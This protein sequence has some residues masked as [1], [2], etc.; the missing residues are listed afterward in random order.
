MKTKKAHFKKTVLLGCMLFAAM[1]FFV[2]P[3]ILDENT[4]GVYY[5]NHMGTGD[6][7]PLASAFPGETIRSMSSNPLFYIQHG[8]GAAEVL[9]MGI[10]SDPDYHVLPLYRLSPVIAVNRAKTQAKILGWRDLVAADAEISIG[11]NAEY[12]LL[13]MN[14]GLEKNW[15]RMD[16]SLTLLKILKK[17]RRLTFLENDLP[18]SIDLPAVMVLFDSQAVQLKKHNPDIDIIYPAEGTVSLPVSL[19]SRK[20]FTFDIHALQQKYQD[21]GFQLPDARA[22]NVLTLDS[23]LY[24]TYI[25]AESRIV[26]ELLHEFRPLRTNKFEN[27]MVYVVLLCILGATGTYYFFRISDEIL[28]R[29]VAA[30]FLLLSYWIMVRLIRMLAGYEGVLHRYA[31]YLYYVALLYVPMLFVWISLRVSERKQPEGYRVMQR[32]T[33][34]IASALLV[35]VLTNDLHE[36]VFRFTEDGGYRHGLVM[37]FIFSYYAI[38]LL[39]SLVLLLLKGVRMPRRKNLLMPGVTIG[40]LVLYT[41]VFNIFLNNKIATEMTRAFVLFIFLVFW[42]SVEF[43]LIPLNAKHRLLFRHSNSSLEIYDHDDEIVYLPKERTQYE[44]YVN[45]SQAIRG[46]CVRWHEDRS[47]L[48]RLFREEAAV[49]E[50]LEEN[51]ELLKQRLSI[52]EEMQSVITRNL[53][54]ERVKALIVKDLLRLDKSILALQD[55][56]KEKRQKKLSAAALDLIHLKHRSNLLMLYLIGEI[57]RSEDFL[58]SLHAI[59][60]AAHNMGVQCEFTEKLH[61]NLAFE[62]ADVLLSWIVHIMQAAMERNIPAGC[63]LVSKEKEYTFTL[64]ISTGSIRLTEFL[65]AFAT[66][67]EADAYWRITTESHPLYHLAI[68]RGVHPE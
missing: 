46:G 59:G 35:L 33:L 11:A 34:G 5:L 37:I 63:S 29:Q 22:E 53:I 50:K 41:I 6:D 19:L 44:V 47:D 16:Q 24:G 60:E 55:I 9:G 20:P 57:I 36:L 43:G 31:W 2:L 32:I 67:P 52:E 14:Y 42:S 61:G 25:H 66:M 49:S 45:R 28:R 62:Q 51:Y 18:E 38:S 23:D 40:L 10:P 56:P 21:A 39:T 54:Q 3:F 30:V 1:A 12:L 13:G 65:S 48:Q 68:F 27:S 8:V 15:R 17:N 58:L 64:Y 26:R 7:T 4:E